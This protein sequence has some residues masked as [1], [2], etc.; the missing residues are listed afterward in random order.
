MKIYCLRFDHM[1]H[2]DH[3]VLNSECADRYAAELFLG[4]RQANGQSFRGEYVAL[5]PRNQYLAEHGRPVNL[6]AR[7]F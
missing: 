4:D 2:G 5:I 3:I 6:P 1:C 7:G